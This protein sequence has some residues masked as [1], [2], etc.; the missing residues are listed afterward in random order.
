MNQNG[1]ISD[2]AANHAKKTCVS[3]FLR[4]TQEIQAKDVSQAKK[5]LAKKNARE[6]EWIKSLRE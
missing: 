1:Q 6:V 4:R 2:Q 5:Y 3:P